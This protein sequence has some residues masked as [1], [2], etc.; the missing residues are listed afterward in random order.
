LLGRKGVGSKN[1]LLSHV[2]VTIIL[3]LFFF[4]SFKLQYNDMP[5]RYYDF[6]SWES[7]GQQYNF[8]TRWLGFAVFTFVVIQ[9]LFIVY[10]V[11]SL[12]AKK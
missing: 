4:V 7:Y 6:S 9:L 8:F 5:M 10:A 12:V 11:V 2:A 3:L 1:V